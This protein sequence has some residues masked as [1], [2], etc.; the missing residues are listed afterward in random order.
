[1]KKRDLLRLPDDFEA[2]VRALLNTPPAPHDTVG[3]RKAA[4]KPHAKPPKAK[5]KKRYKRTK[6]EAAAHRAA[7]AEGVRYKYESARVIKS[8]KAPSKTAK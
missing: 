4:P 1:V 7:K 6:E 8:R 2:N 3:S 5:R